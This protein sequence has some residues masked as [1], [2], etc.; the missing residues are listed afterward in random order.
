M[1]VRVVCEPRSCG[2]FEALGLRFVGRD[3]AGMALLRGEFDPGSVAAGGACA[4]G[5][6]VFASEADEASSVVW[7]LL[8]GGCGGEEGLLELAVASGVRLE[9]ARA[10]LEGFAAGGWLERVAIEGGVCALRLTEAGR[11]AG[12][13]IRSGEDVQPP[14]G[15]G[16]RRDELGRPAGALDEAL[17]R[18]LLAD[19]APRLSTK[20]AALLL[21]VDARTLRNYKKKQG[22][23]QGLTRGR[24]K[25]YGLGELV[26]FARARGLTLEPKC[27]P[28]LRSALEALRERLAA[29]PSEGP[30]RSHHVEFDPTHSSRG[31]P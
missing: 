27:V 18:D 20:E 25:T 16:E 24:E 17:L 30:V 11:V 12:A 26:D 28:T 31:R 3:R 13:R 8:E 15:L 2:H 14:A 5:V 29:R 1:I 4:D 19:D 23:P 7:S 22:F 9:A 6:A 10:A 21:G